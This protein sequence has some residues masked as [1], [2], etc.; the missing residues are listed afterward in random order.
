MNT[1]A[2]PYRFHAF[3]RSL[4]SGKLRPALRYKQLWYEER[5]ANVREII[6]RTGLGFIPILVTPEDE[7]W[8]DTSEI[9]DR[10]E[11][12][13]P[14]PPLFPQ[15]PFARMAALRLK[16]PDTSNTSAWRILPT[17]VIPKRSRS[18]LGVSA[19][20]ISISQ[21]LQALPAR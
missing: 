12:R 10:L 13:Y 11:A 9:L 21:L 6:E 17:K 16:T 14:E 2:A 15:T 19:S 8:Q 1:S 18:Y 3:E 4:F 5:H 7:T 20:R